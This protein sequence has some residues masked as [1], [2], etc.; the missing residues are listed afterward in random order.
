MISFI[1][2]SAV[3]A[4]LSMLYKVGPAMA[5]AMRAA[6]MN[7]C[8][9]TPSLLISAIKQTYGGKWIMAITS[10][11]GFCFKR[12]PAAK[13]IGAHICTVV[14]LKWS[15]GRAATNAM[16]DELSVRVLAQLTR[17]VS[18]L[19]ISLSCS[20]SHLMDGGRSGLIWQK[21][22]NFG[23]LLSWSGGQ[24]TTLVIS[25]SSGQADIW[26]NEQ[27]VSSLLVGGLV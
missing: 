21:G 3:P 20:Y 17:A 26:S 12:D 22:R 4:S 7:R 10:S 27:L 5:E 13:W 6:K 2:L 24:F 25:S 15:V 14:G 23:I 9:S 18:C 8:I 1:T 11:A 16:V 19:V